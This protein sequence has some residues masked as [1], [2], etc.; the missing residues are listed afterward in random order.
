MIDILGTGKLF[1]IESPPPL[2]L[3]FLLHP[4]AAHTHNTHIHTHTHRHIHKQARSAIF[5]IFFNCINCLPR[6]R[7]RV[8]S[9]QGHWLSL[10][11][12]TG[13]HQVPYIGPTGVESPLRGGGLDRAA[14]VFAPLPLSTVAC[15]HTACRS[16][17]LKVWSVTVYRQRPGPGLSDFHSHLLSN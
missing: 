8:V 3:C 16:L 15:T 2:T 9:C 11:G 4:Q 10:H 13:T 7:G 17:T 6:G 1:R 12:T 5:S 14:P